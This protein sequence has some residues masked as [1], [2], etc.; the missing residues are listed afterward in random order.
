MAPWDWTSPKMLNNI[1]EMSASF[2]PSLFGPPY[3]RQGN[4]QLDFAFPS[5]LLYEHLCTATVYTS[6]NDFMKTNSLQLYSNL[7]SCSCM[8]S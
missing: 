6:F 2:A 8:K 5:S 3:R 1:N 7:S 4:V